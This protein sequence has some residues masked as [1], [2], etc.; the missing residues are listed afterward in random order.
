LNKDPKYRN[1]NRSQNLVCRNEQ[2]WFYFSG[3]QR[4]PWAL[5]YIE[6]I[7]WLSF[8]STAKNNLFYSNILD[9]GA[10]IIFF[11]N[12]E[13]VPSVGIFSLKINNNAVVM[14]MYPRD[15]AVWPGTDI[16]VKSS[17]FAHHDNLQLV[18]HT[19]NIYSVL[20]LT[21]KQPVL[22]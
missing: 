22:P 19:V 6:I 15:E 18:F 13:E 5:V 14:T 12:F 1:V 20:V 7:N 16:L 9:E 17:D 2:N 21:W 4:S 8:S 3:D 11:Q 10:I